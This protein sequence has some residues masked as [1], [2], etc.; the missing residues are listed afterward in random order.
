MSQTFKQYVTWSASVRW[1]HWINVLSV[2]SLIFIGL[3]MLYK[4]ELGISSLEAKIALKE[5]HVIVG[6]VFA[7]N[8]IIR[9]LMAFIGDSSARFKAFIPGKGYLEQLKSY[10]QSLHNKQ[11]QQFI[12]HNPIGKLAVTLIFSLLLILLFSGLIRAGTDVYMPP[13]GSS[14]VEFIAEPGTDPATLVP[15]QKEGV[16]A[17]KMAQLKAFKGPFGKIHLYTAYFLMLIILVHIAAVIRAEVKEGDSIVSSMFS[18]K[19]ILSKE[20]EDG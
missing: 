11:P 16:N 7:T 1:F 18:G 6:Y 15:Y 12:G 10:H 2:L 13:F 17:E 4:K 20:P 8:L 19:K 9:V 5:V 14:V 3:I